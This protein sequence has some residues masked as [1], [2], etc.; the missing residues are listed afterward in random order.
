MKM[1]SVDNTYSV[2]LPNVI[3][4]LYRYGNITIYIIGTFANVLCIY[5]FS[6]KSWR[7]NV[8]IFYFLVCL[9]LSCAYQNSVILGTA[10]IIGFNVTLSNANVVLCKLHNYC[11]V[12]FSTLLPTILV[13]AS[14]DRLLLTSQD[15]DTRLYSSRRLAYFSI[16]ISTLFWLIFNIHILIQVSIQQIDALTW[17]CYYDVSTIYFDFFKY[18]LLAFN[19]LFCLLMIVLSAFSYKNVQQIRIV[20][21]H[22]QKQFRSM[23]KK[24]FQLL[25]CLF[26]HDIFYISVSIIPSLYSIYLAVT[27]DQ[28]RTSFEQEIIDFL[29][30]LFNFIYFSFYSSSF[31]IFITASKAFRLEVKRFIC[32]IYRSNSIVPSGDRNRLDAVEQT[33]EKSTVPKVSTIVMSH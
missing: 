14:I 5:F 17:I 16:S 8:C 26:V 21:R 1:L 6:K 7:K 9:I 4:N 23:K 33:N 11:A 10:L 12:L 27:H 32:K 20:S 28:V 2:I 15:I 22:P 29:D 30:N 25:R 13:L 31:F 19:C 18:S 24:D 3:A